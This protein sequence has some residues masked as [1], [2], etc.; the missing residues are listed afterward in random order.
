MRKM[1]I[2]TFLLGLG[3]SIQAQ[4]KF[5]VGINA[6]VALSRAT[7]LDTLM[8][9]FLRKNR[10]G[11]AFGISAT[12]DL[13]RAVSFIGGINYVSKGYKINNDTHPSSPNIVRKLHSVTIPLGISFRQH[14]NST[15]FIRENFGLVMSMNFR[16][17]STRLY[18]NENRKTF[19]V[20][21]TSLSN[22]YPM[23]FL[24]L[25]MGGKADN[26]DRYAIGVNYYQSFVRDSDV[27]LFAGPNMSRKAPLSYRGGF[28]N[29]SFTYY[30]NMTNFKKADEF[31]Y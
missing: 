10:T 5:L 23:F 31:F 7:P 1:V 26:G 20:L 21:E 28:L 11:L 16:N 9:H 17:D 6:G 3:F 18:N 19:S 15:N 13:N 25:E 12:F 2:L 22:F 29:I 8:T 30:F 27:D 4:S 14:F 24:G